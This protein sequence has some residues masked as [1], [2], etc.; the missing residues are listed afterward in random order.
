MGLGPFTCGVLAVSRSVRIESNYSMPSRCHR[1]AWC[2]KALL[3]PH[4]VRSNEYIGG[5]SVRDT[6]EEDVRSRGH[7]PHFTEKAN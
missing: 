5:V 3:H 1:I 2:G 7:G 4:T 6:W